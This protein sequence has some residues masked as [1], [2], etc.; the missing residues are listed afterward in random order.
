MEKL[1]LP[2]QIRDVKLSPLYLRKNFK[3]PAVYYGHKEKTLPLQ[4]EY[5]DFRKIYKKTGTSQIFELEIDGKKKPVLIHEVQ[6]NPLTDR[7]DH[8]DFIHINMNED[9]TAM[10]PVEVVGVAPAVKNF[11]GI[12]TTLRHEIEV[13]CL[14]AN[15]PH[16]IQVDVSGL[17]QIHSSIH[18]KDLI[19]P[20]S[21]AVHG[22]P[23]DVVVTVSQVRV[24]E[25]TPVA[26]TA[27][28]AEGASPAQGTSPA[29]GTEA[30]A[31]AKA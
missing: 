18:I 30:A 5:Q 27:V 9:I 25:E 14:P 15:L 3:I 19:I 4:I 1:V 31:P 12:L 21:V 29:A 6:F 17:E 20:A 11:G 2:A 24:Q 7:V 13:R 8:V 26:A 10:I 23:D 22:N 28:P 16:S